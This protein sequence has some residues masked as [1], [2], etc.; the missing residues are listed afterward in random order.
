MNPTYFKRHVLSLC[1]HVSLGLGLA[2]SL[3]AVAASG[4]SDDSITIYSRLQP[5]AVSPDL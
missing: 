3:P 2:C 4:D 1:I 5:G